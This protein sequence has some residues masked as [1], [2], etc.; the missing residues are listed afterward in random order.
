MRELL[1]VCLFSCVCELYRER[2]ILRA[3][4]S[5]KSFL[6]EVLKGERRKKKSKSRRNVDNPLPEC[7]IFYTRIICSIALCVKRRGLVKG[8]RDLNLV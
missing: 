6:K 2:K 5:D 1:Y 7:K 4:A 8:F 3:R